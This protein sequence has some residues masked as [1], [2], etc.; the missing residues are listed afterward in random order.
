MKIVWTRFAIERLRDIY[1]YYSEKANQVL[2][3]KIRKGIVT[4]AKK[5]SKY[6]L[7][8]Q[9]QE[10]LAPLQLE[11]RYFLKNHYKIVYRIVND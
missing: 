7:S 8:G 9:R 5:I 2:A 6:P 11:Y 1:Q 4:E 3:A 10:I